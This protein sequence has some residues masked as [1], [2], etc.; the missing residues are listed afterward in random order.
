M[1]AVLDAAL[2]GAE[3]FR[4]EDGRLPLAVC[5][6]EK[7]LAARELTALAQSVREL[8]KKAGVDLYLNG[9]VDVALAC[10]ADGVH[11]PGDGMRPADVRLIAPGL[12]IALST[13][14][15]REVDEAARARVDFVVYGPVF[16]TPSKQGVLEPRGIDGLRAVCGNG[17]DVLALGGIFPDHARLCIEAGASGVAVIRAAMAAP[18][19]AQGIVAFLARYRKQK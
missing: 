1:L 16:A 12:K 18:D 13:H 8:T 15:K 4:D 17:V 10:G 11:L 2:R 7:D 19:P 5:L 6:R 3:P 9:R 14:T